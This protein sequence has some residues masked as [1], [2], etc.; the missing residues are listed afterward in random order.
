MSKA[1]KGIGR[2]VSKIVKGIGKGIKKLAKSTLG[3]VVLTVAAG[4]ILGPAVGSLMQSAGGA[5]AAGAVEGSLASVVGSGL[6]SVGSFLGGTG[7]AAGSGLSGALEA[8]ATSVTTSVGNVVSGVKGLFGGAPAA[9]PEAAS[10]WV[11]AEGGAG[12]AGGAAADASALGAS[13]VP[14]GPDSWAPPDMGNAVP[15]GPDS[16]APPQQTSNI[17]PSLA[18]RPV[19]VNSMAQPT[20]Q[21]YQMGDPGLRPPTQVPGQVQ[22]AQVPTPGGIG[23]PAKV[24]NTG[25][26]QGWLSQIMN[27]SRA[28]SALITGG[29]QLGGGLIN[30]YGQARS[31]QAAYDRERERVRRNQDVTA[32]RV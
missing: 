32:L 14:G 31:A 30:G 12:Y 27:D 28:K 16:W 22:M 26:S 19:S 1:I 20:P 21:P 11:S 5:L 2:A 25:S 29:M 9:A 4:L 6:S 7:A 10:G 24:V 18:E 13:M 3:K 15:G 8:A 17:P 23:A